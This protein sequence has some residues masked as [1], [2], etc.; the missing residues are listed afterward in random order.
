MPSRKSLVALTAI[1]ALTGSAL[2]ADT[3]AA[4]FLRPGLAG[5]RLYGPRLYAPPHPV[6]GGSLQPAFGWG[7]CWQPTRNPRQRVWG[8]CGFVP[9]SNN[10]IP[11]Y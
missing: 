4:A 5:P 8:P 10:H 1:V 2:L 9:P 3:A 6:G 7:S 11:G